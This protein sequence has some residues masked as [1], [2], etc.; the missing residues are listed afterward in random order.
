VATLNFIPNSGFTGDYIFNFTTVDN[1]GLVSA[2]AP[3]TVPVVSSSVRIGEPPVAY[4]FNAPAINSLSVA[5]LSTALTGTDADGTV[6]SFIIT[7][8]TPALEGTLSYCTTG[9]LPSCT[10]VSLPLGIA[11]TPAQKATIQFTPNANFV[12]TSTFTYTVKDNDGN[13]G[14][15]ATVTIPVLNNPP[16]AQNI[17]NSPREKVAVATTLNPL[18][19]TDADGT[20]VSYTILSVPTASQGTLRV[21]TTAPSTG[22]TDVTAGQVLTPAQISQLAFTPNPTG[23]SPVVTFLYSSR[24]N[25]NN[26]SNIAAVNI[27]LF[28]PSTPVPPIAN[29]IAAPRMNNSQACLYLAFRHLAQ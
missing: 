22:C 28:D 3:F 23:T 15:T 20:V 2:P 18:A 12:G 16:V 24:D 1:N 13:L 9:T 6:D 21:C 26:T 29:N 25:S 17:N 10:S 5:N 19:S 14:N 11:L 7:S 8:I 4:S 27:P